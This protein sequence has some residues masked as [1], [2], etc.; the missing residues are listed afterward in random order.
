MSSAEVRDPAEQAAQADPTPPAADPARAIDF[1]STWPGE[2]AWVYTFPD[3][4][5]RTELYEGNG[6][7]A[8]ESQVGR[9]SAEEGYLGASRV[10]PCTA[11]THS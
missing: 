6:L 4:R 3:G 2:R 11:G 8:L 10:L 1:L 5:T 7:R 9:R